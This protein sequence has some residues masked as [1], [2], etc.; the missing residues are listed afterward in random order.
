[1]KNRRPHYSRH[2]RPRL[3]KSDRSGKGRYKDYRLDPALRHV[4]GKIGVPNIQTFTPDPF[5][6]EALEKIEDNDVLVSAP[7]GAGKTWIASRTIERHL[8]KGLRIWYASPLKALS[9][10]LYQEFSHEFGPSSCGILTGERKENPDAPVIVGTTEILRNQLYDAMHA[11]TS[12]SSD[13][14]ILD[15]AHYLSDPDRGVV[16]EEV[17]IYLPARVRL[18]LLSATISNAEEVCSWLRNN[19]KTPFAVVRAHQRPVPLQTLFLLPEG[20]ITPLS[21]KKG[22]APKVKKYVQSRATY[23][24]FRGRAKTE[25]GDIISCL[26]KFDLLPAIFFLK[27]RMDC[28][29]ALDMCTMPEGREGLKKHLKAE[30]SSFLREYPHLKDHRQMG[31]LLR[32]LVA[33]HHAGQLPYW[34]VL[35]EKMMKK[36]YLEAI[37]STSTVAAGVNFPARTVALIQSDRFD[38]HEFTDLTATDLHQMIGRAGRRGMDNIGFALVIPGIHQDAK[39]IHELMYSPPEPLLS[40]IRINFS[41]TL[42]LLLSHRPEEVKTLLDL[43]FAAFLHARSETPIQSQWDDLIGSLKRTLPDAVCDAGDP[44]EILEYIRK[45]AE[46]RK[47]KRRLATDKADKKS[48]ESLK[49]FLEKG[50]LFHHRNKGIHVLFYW[51]TDHERLICASHNIDKKVRLRKGKIR[52]KKIPFTKITRLYDYILD[53][54]EKHTTSSLQTMIDSIDREGLK[55]LDTA[56]LEQTNKSAKIGAVEERERGLPCEH[57]EHLRDCHG[58]RNGDVHRILKTFKWLSNSME[59][60]S[61]GLWLSFKRHLRFLKETGFVD[62]KDRLTSDGIWASKLRLDQPLL[63][64][65]AIR[66]GGFRDLGPE[67][68]AGCIAVFVW[69]KDQDVDIHTAKHQDLKIMEEAFHRLL[70]SMEYVRRLKVARGFENPPVLYWPGAAV[71]LWSRGL[72]WK[73]LL[74]HI[75]IGEGDMASMITRTA[76]HL[77]QVATLEA[78]HPELALVA[79]RAIDTIMREPVFIP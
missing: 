16:W 6:L 35:I 2:K 4:F 44:Y 7:T 30:V 42:N 40:Q 14:V 36:G 22:P 20:L 8:Q 68:M 43:S 75:P 56:P 1:M 32:S 26:R 71:F 37:F 38:G 53:I 41:M 67:V 46:L 50:R 28:D 66:K 60:T 77:R 49:P 10:S 64:A 52:L 24:R 65:E 23:G 59:G 33:S 15:E 73:D 78:T 13:L 12:I 55:T 72:P 31:P 19:R 29:R 76:D 79:V 74:Y 62:E 3:K 57:C 9:N 39:L 61:S 21:G 27:S 5:Q 69:D 17:L 48:I 58:K 47:E 18:L 25:F 45:R 11:G 51:Y 54:P 70:V 63:I 34:K